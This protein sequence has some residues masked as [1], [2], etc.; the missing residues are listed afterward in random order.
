MPV[1]GRLSPCPSCGGRGLLT[2]ERGPGVEPCT[3]CLG[4]GRVYS[5]PDLRGV[6]AALLEEK[7]VL[8]EADMRLLL[9]GLDAIDRRVAALEDGI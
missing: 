9:L 4:A 2:F 3:V 7:G 8:L 1:R 6:F 5:D